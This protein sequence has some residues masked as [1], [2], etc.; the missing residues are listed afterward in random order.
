MNGKEKKMINFIPHKRIKI[1]FCLLTISYLAAITVGLFKSSNSLYDQPIGGDFTTYWASSHMILS[2]HILDIYDKE[3]LHQVHKGVTG[4]DKFFAIMSYPP[5]YFLLIGPLA[6]LPYLPSLALWIG[7]TLLLF[8]FVLRRI[9]PHPLT[10]WASLAFPGIFGNFVN[11]NNGFLSGIFLGTGLLL[12]KLFP[13][14]GGLFL[15]LLIYKPHLAVLIPFALIAGRCWRALLGMMTSGIAFIM[16]SIMIFGIKPWLSFFKNIPFAFEALETRSLPLHEIPSVFGELLLI[17]I[18]PLHARNIHIITA[19][20][21][22]I[23]TVWIWW[24]RTHYQLRASALAI[25]CLLLS[26]HICSHDLAI[27]ALPLAWMGFQL[28]TDRGSRKEQAVLVLIWLA[29]LFSRQIALAIHIQMMP[30]ILFG[31]LFFILLKA[32]TYQLLNQKSSK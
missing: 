9:A 13:F 1:Y 4:Q 24:N 27:L 31:F 6:F 22:V 21:A 8:L 29:P 26:P 18:D 11:G 7:S 30:L 16:M 28:Y 20:I 3:K 12:M 2:G 23:I 10:I 19:L 32:K 17:G 25:G 5:T 14:I 15:G